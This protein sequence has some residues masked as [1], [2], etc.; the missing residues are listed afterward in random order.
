MSSNRHIRLKREYLYRKS[1]ERKDLAEAAERREVAEAAAS[2]KR[3]ANVSS[4]AD[5]KRARE[6]LDKRAWDDA[7][8]DGD[9]ATHVDDEYAGARSAPPRVCVTTSREPS[10]K[11][12]E[13]VKEVRLVLPTSVR[14]NRGQFT[15]GELVQTCRASDF[16]DVVICTEHRGDP[17]GL[18]VC[19]LP[20]GPT[21]RFSLSECVTRHDIGREAAGGASEQLPHLV[22]EDFTSPVGRRLA[23]ILQHL[24]PVPRADS[25]RVV[26]FFNRDDVV[27][28]RHHVFKAGARGAVE[29]VEVGPRFEMR[30]YEIRLGTVDQRDVAEV[31]WALRSFTNKRGRILSSGE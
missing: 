14:V 6:L 30:P 16:S 3:L 22:F 1:Q 4:A 5:A 31:E 17:D 23:S 24:F 9:P 13:F 20:Y 10:S 21:A 7:E 26:T 11:L 25:K 12:K 15:L 29:L 18:I 19:H 2:G 28:F 27:S 8:R